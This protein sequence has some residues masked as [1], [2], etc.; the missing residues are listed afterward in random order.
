MGDY[1]AGGAL[2]ESAHSTAMLLQEASR[3]CVRFLLASACRPVEALSGSQN[4]PLKE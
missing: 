1:L 2:N 4:K 3:I